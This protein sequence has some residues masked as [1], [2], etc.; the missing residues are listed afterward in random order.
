MIR[1]SLGTLDPLPFD[2][3]LSEHVSE[4][5]RVLLDVILPEP[6]AR[7]GSILR[8]RQRELPETAPSHDSCIIRDNT[9]GGEVFLR[10]GSV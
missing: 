10:L 5:G 2:V 3:T 9:G 1:H 7:H 6:A 4:M 8:F